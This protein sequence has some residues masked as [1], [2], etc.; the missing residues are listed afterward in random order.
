[1]S[2]AAWTCPGWS[3]ASNKFATEIGIYTDGLIFMIDKWNLLVNTTILRQTLR[4]GAAGSK[5]VI[6]G[7][8]VLSGITERRCDIIV[9]SSGNIGVVGLK[10]IVSSKR[11]DAKEQWECRNNTYPWK[12]WQGGMDIELTFSHNDLRK[13]IVCL[14]YHPRRRISSIF[15]I[16]CQYSAPFDLTVW[17]HDTIKTAAI[18]SPLPVKRTGMP[19]E[20]RPGSNN[21]APCFPAQ[22]FS[23]VPGKKVQ[24]HFLPE[25]IYFTSNTLLILL[26]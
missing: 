3:D 1:M 7:K 25:T 23:T 15:H 20:R 21:S 12:K 22:I 9:E 13:Y 16:F 4:R 11:L 18:R 6:N 10:T 14:L 19:W 24:M 2:E 17:R 8:I 5:I 26:F